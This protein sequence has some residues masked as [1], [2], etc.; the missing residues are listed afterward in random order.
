[1]NFATLQ[2]LFCTLFGNAKSAIIVN[3]RLKMIRSTT[4][5]GLYLP[6]MWV[7]GRDTA[8]IPVPIKCHRNSL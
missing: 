8:F 5:E 6:I 1:M 7:D 2:Y 4:F 3:L